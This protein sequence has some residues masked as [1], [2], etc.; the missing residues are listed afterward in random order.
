MGERALHEPA[1]GAQAGAA[2]GAA[3]GDQRFHAEAPDETVVL[4]VVVAGQ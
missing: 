2:L 1:L 4:V 3:V